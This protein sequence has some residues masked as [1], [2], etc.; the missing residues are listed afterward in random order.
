MIT[1]FDGI[2][3]QLIEEPGLDLITDGVRLSDWVIQEG[4]PSLLGIV[5][6]RFLA[7]YLYGQELE[8]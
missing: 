5:L 2:N 8:A 7:M 3:V 1:E 4:G 6:D